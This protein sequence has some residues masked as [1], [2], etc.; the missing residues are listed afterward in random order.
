MHGLLRFDPRA[1]IPR[2]DRG[3]RFSVHGMSNL[4]APGRTVFST[5]GAADPMLLIAAFS[6]RLA[7]DPA[8]LVGVL[9]PAKE[10]V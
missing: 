1:L 3:P 8:E 9:R 5:S 2:S 4:Y 6:H 10:A 7:E